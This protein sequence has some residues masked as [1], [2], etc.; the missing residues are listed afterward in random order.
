MA[1][2]APDLQD[3]RRLAGLGFRPLWL[4]PPFSGG[5][6]AGKH[7][8]DDDWRS[9]GFVPPD[10]LAGP[11]GPGCNLGIRC[12]VVDGTSLAVVAVNAD[13]ADVA[14][15]VERACGMT[16]LRVTTARGQILLYRHPGVEV[17][18]GSRLR[19]VPLEVLG[20]GTQ[21]VVLPSIHRSGFV[22]KEHKLWD[23]LT[24]SAAPLFPVSALAE[25]VA[26]PRL[27]SLRDTLSRMNLTPPCAAWIGCMVASLAP[28]D[29][30][31]VRGLIPRPAVVAFDVGA[32]C[33]EAGAKNTRPSDVSRADAL[34]I[35]SAIAEVHVKD[36]N[37]EDNY[38]IQRLVRR[39]FPSSDHAV[40]DLTVTYGTQ[41]VVVTGL[42]GMEIN[43]YRIVQGRVTEGGVVL[44]PPG[45]RWTP[46][47]NGKLRA[48]IPAV[49]TVMESSDA[50]AVSSARAV[51]VDLLLA[52][53]G[54]ETQ[55]DL[56]RGMVV[57]VEGEVYA[58]PTWTMRHMRMVLQQDK[59]SREDCLAAAR[60]LGMFEKQPLLSGGGRP[61]VWAFK[62]ERLR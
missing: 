38:Q 31:A 34:A 37:E 60:E 9:A 43:A 28:D 24:V 21:I 6:G 25:T 35:R 53:K 5:A 4:S 20:D 49:E 27:S 59:L 13:S 62:E 55:E 15:Y 16:P 11:P 8:V 23:P 39:Q 57:R 33:A 19:G 61:R 2:R 50:T 30:G 10:D 42:S 46:I 26:G 18:L 14:V 54:G 45:K 52:G 41:A 51:L 22:Y 56:R 48:A 47:W 36:E 29:V 1:E 12:G 3:A 44:P 40:F 17:P 7:P 58:N 32:Q